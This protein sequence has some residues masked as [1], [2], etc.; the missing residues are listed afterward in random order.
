MLWKMIRR[1]LIISLSIGLVFF[2]LIMADLILTRGLFLSAAIDYDNRHFVEVIEQ[3]PNVV[4]EIT[5][6]TNGN[7]HFQ[8]ENNSIMPK[9]FTAS[10]NSDIQYEMNDTIFFMHA[11]WAQLVLPDTVIGIYENWG[12]GTGLAPAT[13]NPFEVFDMEFTYEELIQKSFYN[14]RYYH[15]SDQFED[16][17]YKEPMV[18]DTNGFWIEIDPLKTIIPCSDSIEVHYFFYLNSFYDN[19]RYMVKSNGIQLSYLD[20]MNSWL[21]HERERQIRYA[22]ND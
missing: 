17:I 20:L 12:C 22:K 3:D 4:Y 8:F 6:L 13:V 14:L 10:R 7:Y 9:Y 19:E 11:D 2:G 18:K 5:P 1:F 15:Y 16:P 21:V